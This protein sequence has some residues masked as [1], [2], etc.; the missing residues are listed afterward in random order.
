MEQKLW[1]VSYVDIETR[2]AHRPFF[3]LTSNVEATS[4]KD[5][6]EYVMNNFSPPKYGEFKASR[7]KGV[8]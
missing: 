2:N 5:A 7:K 4:R 1:K 8:K 6:I 3:K